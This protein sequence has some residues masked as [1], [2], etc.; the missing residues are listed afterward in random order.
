MKRRGMLLTGPCLLPSVNQEPCLTLPSTGA[1]AVS[2]LKH[3]LEATSS[4]FSH[5]TVVQGK[6]RRLWNQLGLNPPSVTD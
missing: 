6:E 1:S 3:I 2:A 5:H 4:H